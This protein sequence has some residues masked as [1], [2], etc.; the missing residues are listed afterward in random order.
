[1]RR[2]DG[3]RRGRLCG[4]R[5][6]MGFDRNPMR[7][8]SD[9]LQAIVRAGLLAAFLAVAPPAAF[10]AGHGVYA[11]GLQARAAACH[12]VP[13]AITGVTPVVAGWAR[14][15]PPRVRLSV[16]W[17]VPG[18]S[19]RTGEIITAKNEVTGTTT[20]VWI[21]QDGRLAGPPL[22]RAEVTGQAIS[23]AAVVVAA[24]ALLL[25][26]AGRMVSLL[27][28]RHRLACWEAD[29]SVTEPQWTGRR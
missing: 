1:M 17:A 19:S 15:G 22:S 13:A 11:S 14:A 10:Y 20:T 7:R 27:L 23:A 29:W 12:R 9:R 26:V 16:R 28:D 4:L 3:P 6:R 5:R 24:V 2:Y 25:A 18:G 21:G 8:G